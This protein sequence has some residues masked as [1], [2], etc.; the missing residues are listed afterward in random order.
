M[1]YKTKATC[2][3]RFNKNW[4]TTTILHINI[5]THT[6]TYYT[7]TRKNKLIKKLNLLK[8]L[9]LNVVKN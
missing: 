2:A 1:R 4:E 9:V 7:V 3:H 5:D 6:H 8:L